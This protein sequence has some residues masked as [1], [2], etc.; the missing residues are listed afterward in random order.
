MLRKK[1]CDDGNSVIRAILG[2]PS[3]MRIDA[4]MAVGWR[5]LDHV[6]VLREERLRR[7][8]L[9]LLSQLGFTTIKPAAVPALLFSAGAAVGSP[10]NCR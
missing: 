10:L 2:W 4:L 1:I 7:E 9:P 3:V 5:A 6:P 8:L